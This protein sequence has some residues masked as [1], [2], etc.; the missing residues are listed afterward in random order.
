MREESY[1]REVFSFT[2]GA[3]TWVGVLAAVAPVVPRYILPPPA[4][5]LLLILHLLADGGVVAG[6][7]ESTGALFVRGLG[8]VARRG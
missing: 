7:G 6:A 3:R 4:N 2:D 1:A 8:K 5:E